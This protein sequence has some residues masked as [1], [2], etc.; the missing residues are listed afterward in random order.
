MK[1]YLVYKLPDDREE[2][3]LAQQ[4]GEMLACIH[5]YQEWLRSIDKYE[6]EQ[7]SIQSARAKF[8]EMFDGFLL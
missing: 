4:A 3:E 8:H 5:D 1:A 7:W 6:T 2:F